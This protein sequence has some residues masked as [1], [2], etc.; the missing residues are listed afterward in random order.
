MGA[1]VG[2]L[3]PRGGVFLPGY[4]VFLPGCGVFLP[5]GGVIIRF[6]AGSWSACVVKGVGLI[7]FTGFRTTGIGGGV[8]VLIRERALGRTGVFITGDIGGVSPP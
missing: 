5:G 7:R 8:G 2:V 3:L 6:L 4:G 1:S